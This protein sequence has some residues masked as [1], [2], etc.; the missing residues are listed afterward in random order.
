MS[1]IGHAA[2]VSGQ[3]RCGNPGEE[4]R[5]TPLCQKAFIFYEKQGSKAN[6]LNQLEK[7]DLIYSDGR[8]SLNYT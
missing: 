8:S 2:S 6:Q 5:A 4:I 7:T 1:D 3:D